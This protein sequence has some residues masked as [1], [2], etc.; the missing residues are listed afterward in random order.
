MLYHSYCTLNDNISINISRLDKTT[1]WFF[2]NLR[3]S[4]FKNPHFSTRQMFQQSEFRLA[5]I[6]KF[7]SIGLAISKYISEYHTGPGAG[8]DPS[9]IA[10]GCLYCISCPVGAGAMEMVWHLLTPTA[11]AKVKGRQVSA[12]LVI[13]SDYS[14]SPQ[15][16]KLNPLND[17]KFVVH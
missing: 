15:C 14:R 5:L 17:I 8:L 7:P 4:I 13:V 1:H 6:L 3:L 12:A 9:L 16:L 11:E 10:A 2:F